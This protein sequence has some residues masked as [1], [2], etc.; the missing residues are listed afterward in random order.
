MLVAEEV[1]TLAGKKLDFGDWEGGDADRVWVRS[2]RILIKQRD[3]DAEDIQP[4]VEEQQEPHKRDE[5]SPMKMNS[6]DF[7]TPRHAIRVGNAAE[8]DSD[9]D[10]VQGYASE[11]DSDRAP[12]PTPSELEEIE[13]DPTLNVGMKKV[14]KPV[15][16]AQLGELV[17]STNA[18]LKSAENDE[19]DKIE[20][21]LKRGEELIRRK[22][23]FGMELGGCC[24]HPWC[25]TQLK[26]YI[27]EE[28]AVN[29]VYTFVGLQNS[30]ELDDFSPKRQGIVTALV[31][32]CPRKSAPYVH[33]AISTA[34]LGA[35]SPLQLYHRGVFQEPVFH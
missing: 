34:V 27:T 5:S 32:C 8:P 12:S 31:A 10:S 1:A 13:K 35:D 19:P 15:Y 23:N 4:L 9:D 3:V 29:L 16:L 26:P 24:I 28:N 20:M 33:R 2:L 11:V 21:A 30:Y 7:A 25:E 17:R 6:S 18:G 14:P 22:R